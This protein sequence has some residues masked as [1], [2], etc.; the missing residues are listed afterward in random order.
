MMRDPYGKEREA[1]DFT[2]RQGKPDPW[3]IADPKIP[4]PAPGPVQKPVDISEIG[5]GVY[6]LPTGEIYVVKPNTAGDRKYAKRLLE[7]PSDR[8]T[9]TGVKVKF[10]FVY[11]RGAIYRLRPEYKMSIARGKELMIKYGRCI[12]CGRHLRVAESVERGIGPVC[13]KSFKDW[14]GKQTDL[15]E[16]QRQ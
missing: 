15:Q 14:R 16:A 11:E 5:I 2:I 4:I 3:A 8:V 1:R 6:E 12:V 9:E 7:S 13:I 10:D